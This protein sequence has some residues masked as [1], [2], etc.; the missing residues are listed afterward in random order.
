MPMCAADK[1]FWRHN[2]SFLL[3]RAEGESINALQKL[4]TGLRSFSVQV[5]YKKSLAVRATPHHSLT[6]DYKP[7]PQFSR[8]QSVQAKWVMRPQQMMPSF[9]LEEKF[10]RSELA[11]YVQLRTKLCGY[12]ST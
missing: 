3:R 4:R 9:L 6:P 2:S 11:V 10:F 1:L 12:Y 7:K 8:F 5:P